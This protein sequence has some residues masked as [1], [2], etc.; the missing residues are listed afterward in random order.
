MNYT[1]NQVRDMLYAWLVKTRELPPNEQNFGER[2]LWRQVMGS[3]YICTEYESHNI[4]RLCGDLLMVSWEKGDEIT[5]L[6]IIRNG[7][8]KRL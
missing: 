5:D 4:K 2:E 3:H 1:D 8:L 6:F 7:H